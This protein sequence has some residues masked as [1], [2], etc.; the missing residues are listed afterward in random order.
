MDDGDNVFKSLED[1]PKG[2]PIML[3]RFGFNY[4]FETLKKIVTHF[5]ATGPCSFDLSGAYQDL[6][7]IYIYR[8]P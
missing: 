8:W 4:V 5:L 1:T 7:Y 2:K 6:I 3:K